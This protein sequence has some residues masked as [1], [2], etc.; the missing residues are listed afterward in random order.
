MSACYVQFS[1]NENGDTVWRCTKYLMCS[2]VKFNETQTKCYHYKCP[3][4]RNKPTPQ[5]LPAISPVEPPLVIKETVEEVLP[6][7]RLCKNPGCAQIVDS[8]LK[9]YCSKNCRKRKNSK[10]Y[11]KRKSLQKSLDKQ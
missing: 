11:R 8:E 6:Q 9:S 1:E 5:I 3:G 10:D 7:S 4:R 2:S